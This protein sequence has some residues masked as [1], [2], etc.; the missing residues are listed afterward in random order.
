MKK[1]IIFFI[2]LII[3]FFLFSCQQQKSE[4]RVNAALEKYL[5][6]WNG[7][8]LDTLDVITSE[9]FQLRINPTFEPAIGRERLKEKILGTRSV[10]PDFTIKAK[11]MIMLGD[12]AL[13][14]TWT[15]SGTFKNAK[16]S[17]NSGKRTEAEGFS[18]IFFHDGIL[19]GEWI[20]YSDLTWYKNLGYQ[21]VLPKKK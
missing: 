14:L 9:S 11:E 5:Y 6:V 10:F 2:F 3:A 20:A 1:V 21:L 7:G 15:I 4:N 17:L 18:I 19:T 16:D 8:I 13:A 12:T